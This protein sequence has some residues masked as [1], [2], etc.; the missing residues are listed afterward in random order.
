[1]DVFQATEELVDEELAVV[2][3]KGR[4]LEH[5]LKVGV[6]DF[7]NDVNIME[8]A[9]MGRD[10]KVFDG[11]DV[12]MLH[13]SKKHDFTKGATSSKGS[14]ESVWDFLDSHFLVCVDVVESVDLSISSCADGCDWGVLFVNFEFSSFR[15]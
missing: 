10:D 2:I 7:G 9:F 6:H 12:L 11:E 3:T 8:E 14:L 1:M 13:M 5:V 4:R 15:S